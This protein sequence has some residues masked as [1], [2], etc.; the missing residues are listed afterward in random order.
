MTVL[1]A[2]RMFKDSNTSGSNKIQCTVPGHADCSSTDTSERST[3]LNCPCF[4]TVST[5]SSHLG[6]T[7]THR[8]NLNRALRETHC[9]RTASDTAMVTLTYVA[10]QQDRIQGPEARVFA[11][12]STWNGGNC[13]IRLITSAEFVRDA[14]ESRYYYS[15]VSIFVYR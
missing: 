14:T 2:G 3:T 9:I 4:T 12:S 5:P 1:V 13:V 11:R 10:T 8:Y 7:M 6:H 15:I